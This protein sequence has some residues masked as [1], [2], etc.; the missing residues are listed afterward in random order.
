VRRVLVAALVVALLALVAAIVLGAS[1][2]L[3]TPSKSESVERMIDAPPEVVWDA[4]AEIDAYREWNP[5]VTEASGDVRVGAELRLRLAPPGGETEEVTVKV[6]TVTPRKLRW[7]DRLVLPGV[8]DEEVTFRVVKISELQ[9]RLEETVRM[10]GLLAP[11]A[12]LAPT[13]QGLEAMAA[14][15]ERRVEG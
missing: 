1:A 5:Y 6:L 10:E 13:T 2:K 14:A 3:D 8:R 7:E 11:W 9:V 15:L 4:L 12:D